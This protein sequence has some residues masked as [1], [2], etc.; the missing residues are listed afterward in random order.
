MIILF[1]SLSSLNT[2]FSPTLFS[3]VK[4][5]SF[6]FP[7][8]HFL[9]A[10]AFNYSFVLLFSSPSIFPCIL[11]FPISPYLPYLL[12]VLLRHLTDAGHQ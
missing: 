12:Q 11:L 1:C 10:A 5:M 8:Y 6:P 7:P 9:T 2:H 3:L 4:R